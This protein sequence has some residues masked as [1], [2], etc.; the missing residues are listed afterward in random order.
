MNGPR[1]KVVGYEVEIIE[2]DTDESECEKYS[3][4]VCYE[5]LSNPCICIS[6]SI[7]KIEVIKNNVHP[8]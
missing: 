5:C 2:S 1:D 4:D 3:F 7:I 8:I 6:A